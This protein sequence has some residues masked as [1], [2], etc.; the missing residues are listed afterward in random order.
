MKHGLGGY[1][2]H[3]CR[4]AECRAANAAYYRRRNAEKKRLGICR[5]CTRPVV[6]E[7]W[8]EKHRLGNLRTLS[9]SRKPRGVCPLCHG[10]YSLSQDGCLRP[11]IVLGEY[12]QQQRP[13]EIVSV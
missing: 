1:N 9:G 2:N 10:E 13:V 8:C 11:H 12:H 4:C 7:V 5:A 3:H 6:T